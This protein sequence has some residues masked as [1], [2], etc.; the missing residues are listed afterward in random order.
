MRFYLAFLLIVGM[1]YISNDWFGRIAITEQSVRKFRFLALTCF[2][3]VQTVISFFFCRLHEPQPFI[4]ASV[5]LMGIISAFE[6][7]V[8]L[9]VMVLAWI[10][11]LSEKR[12]E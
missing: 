4:L 10:V 8:M 12:R 6:T 11:F 1:L 9:F 7:I 3:G 5:A 2:F